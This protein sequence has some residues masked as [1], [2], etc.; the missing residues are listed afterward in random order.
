MPEACPVSHYHRFVSILSA[1]MGGAQACCLAVKVVEP[2]VTAY[3]YTWGEGRITSEGENIA[4]RTEQLEI[5]YIDGMLC[6]AA[7]AC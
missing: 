7:I 6:A 2:K 5:G 1:C 4:V 3:L